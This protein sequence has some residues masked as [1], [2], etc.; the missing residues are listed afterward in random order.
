MV[1]NKLSRPCS[2][3]NDEYFQTVVPQKQVKTENIALT[4]SATFS[5]ITN[6]ANTG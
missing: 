6:K 4:G 5:Q 1:N 2:F 3:K